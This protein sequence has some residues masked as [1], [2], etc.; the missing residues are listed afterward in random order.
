MSGMHAMGGVVRVRGRG[1]RPPTPRLRDWL[2]R[3]GA[4]LRVVLPLRILVVASVQ[5]RLPWRGNVVGRIGADGHGRGVVRAC[6]GQD[7]K[8]L[9]GLAQR[10]P[11]A[12]TQL[13]P[14]P[15]AHRGWMGMQPWTPPTVEV[16]AQTRWL[17]PS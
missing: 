6:L 17:M 7:Q 1:R 2:V 4:S 15:L 9:V 11:S 12:A 5:V 14:S 13:C 10:R 8:A 16:L 3:A